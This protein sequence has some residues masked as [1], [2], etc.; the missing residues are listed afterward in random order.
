MAKEQFAPRFEQFANNMFNVSGAD[1]GIEAL[2][3]WYSKIGAPVTLKEGNIP[4]SDI[5]MLVE[6][7]QAVAK[8]WGAES[9]YTKEMITT[10]LE[11]AKY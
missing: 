7:L 9:L 11:N 6:K 8:M 4:E 5:P 2:K 3:N 10:V 1:A